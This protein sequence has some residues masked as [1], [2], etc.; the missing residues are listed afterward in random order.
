[1]KRRF[2][3][4]GGLVLV[5]VLVVVL[6]LLPSREQEHPATVVETVNQVDAH[7][8]PRDDWRPAVVDML[9]YGGG[10]VR[11]GTESS[12]KLELLEGLVRLSADSIFTVKKSATRQGEP[13]TTIFLQEGRLW[14][15]LVPDQP[16]AFTVDTGNAI[17]AVRDTRL[18]V[19]MADG[20]TLLSVAEGEAV[21][22][23][24]EQSVTVAA[25]QQ[26]TAK[27]GRPPDKPEPMSDEERALWA[28]EGEMP[29]LAPPVVFVDSGQRLS[30]LRSLAVA[31]G[32][33]DGDG[34]LDA[35]VANSR[36]EGQPDMVWLNDGAG[37]FSDSG[38][39]L[40]NTSTEGLALGDL[41]GDGDLDA[42]IAT[43]WKNS[44]WLNDGTGTF[45]DTGQRLSDL[46]SFAVALGDLDGDGDL[47]AFVGNAD[48]E[49]GG[50]PNAVWLNNGT[51]TFSHSGQSLGDSATLVVALGDLDG[52]GDL[53]AF[54]AN[55]DDKA[56]ADEV[57][58]NDG[59]GRFSDTGQ[60]LGNS[61]SHA[62][63]LGDLDGD[64]DIDAFVGVAHGLPD[65]KVWLND[66]AGNFSDSGQDLSGPNVAD[67]ALGDLDGDGDLDAFMGTYYDGNEVWL[68]DGA[69][70]LSPS[71]QNMGDSDS[72][73]LA[74][75]DLD[76]DGD[77]DAFVAEFGWPDGQP[78]KVYFNGK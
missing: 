1:M 60:R 32:D 4:A 47:D 44:I 48:H 43:D 13:M 10:Q 19:R 25:L 78:N 6:L 56:E 75:G 9:I 66:G 53:D 28:T 71:D 72:R 39:R 45:S 15:H 11:T 74:L 38:Q 26:A 67:V 58:L 50:Q 46:L 70:N 42:F 16:H 29:E 57:W 5:S 12:A 55:G 23:A 24:Q 37:Q 31:L 7:A 2:W 14:A 77:L 40:G 65:N 34:D 27:P 69:G 63:A 30:D 64:G 21:L 18:S 52:D 20:E 59:T 62:M 68:N 49:S 33:V 36:G 73:G 41:D 35:L 22:T 51:G 61:S 54:V 17:V 76:G 3:I 8:R